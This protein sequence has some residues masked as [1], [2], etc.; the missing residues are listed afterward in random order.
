M[1]KRYLLAAVMAGMMLVG[2]GGN[3]QETAAVTAATAE[4]VTT[5][6]AEAVT[7]A[8]A[9]EITTATAE[10][11]TTAE[12]S[13][14]ETAE[15][16]QPEATQ[17]DAAAEAEETIEAAAEAETPGEQEEFP[18]YEDNFAVDAQASA[19]FAEAVKKAVEE[20]DLEALADLAEYPLYVGF[21]EGGESVETKEAFLELGADRIFTDPLLNAVSAADETDLSPSMAGFVLTDESGRPNIIFG[22][23]EGK[24]AVNGINY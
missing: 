9:E 6:T 19:E 3:S 14:T 24:L 20:K 11:V 8:T 16:D 2:C 7:A 13:G 12:E 23:R 1:R 15:Q 10:E 21:A 22:V 18:E 4:A 17:E 5:A